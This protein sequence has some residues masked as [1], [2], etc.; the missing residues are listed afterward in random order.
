[1]MDVCGIL[2]PMVLSGHIDEDGCI[3]ECGHNDNHIFKVQNRKL[4]SWEDDYSCQC[5]CWDSYEDGDN[6][7]CVVYYEIENIEDENRNKSTGN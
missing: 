3:K 4:I 7:S 6:E 2:A 1:M 5:G